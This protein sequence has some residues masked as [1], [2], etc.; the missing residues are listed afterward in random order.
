MTRAFPLML[1]FLFAI[2]FVVEAKPRHASSTYA[3]TDQKWISEDLSE[4]FFLL[5]TR[6]G[7]VANP[8]TLP[9]EFDSLTETDLDRDRPTFFIMHGFSSGQDFGERFVP[10]DF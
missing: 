10:G 6:S 7:G 9:K 1:T 5:Y 8:T 2:L 3:R 4:V